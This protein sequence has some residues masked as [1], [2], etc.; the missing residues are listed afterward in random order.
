MG[1]AGEVDLSRASAAAEWRRHWPL[2]ATTLV[3]STVTGQ[4]LQSVGV[5]MKPLSEAFGWSRGQISLTVTFSGIATVLL[6]PFVGAL[7]QNFGP[8]RVALW[9]VPTAALLFGAVGLTGPSIASFWGVFLLY[10][11]AQVAIG[12]VVWASAITSTFN[13]TR[14][15]ALGVGLCGSGFSPIVYPKLSLWFLE[16][17]GWRGVYFGLAVAGAI[18]LLPLL[19]FAFRPGN[20]TVEGVTRPTW[21]LS[22]KEVVR[23]RLY[24]K[25]VFVIIAMGTLMAT[26]SVHLVPLLLDRGLKPPE[27]TSIAAAMGASALV[28]RWMGGF[29]LDRLIA[30]WVV[31]P[32]LA[33]PAAGCVLL[34]E[35][36]TSMLS[37]EIG[38]VLTGLAFG[39]EY[40]MLPFLL[41]RYFGPRAFPKNLGLT[42]SFFGASFAICPPVAGFIY[43]A[44]RSY[45]P[46]LLALSGM[47][48]VGALFAATLPNY[49]EEPSS[50][51]V[52]A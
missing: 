9:A 34:A 3:A 39:V 20:A 29:L 11:I 35:A 18:S 21:G 32:A 17:F 36:S 40:S 33:L 5:A 7:I 46:A 43:D 23:T 1:R 15:L 47:L 8:R 13:S 42:M 24:W 37:V 10:S 4:Q 16:H 30:R 49:P 6:S 26:L 28:G 45:E 12:P 38:V 41:S 19:L 50:S 31:I 44:V 48:I 14:G 2:A 27:A 52:D 51:G 22:E 25:L